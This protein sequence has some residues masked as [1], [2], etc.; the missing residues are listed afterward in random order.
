MLSYLLVLDSDRVVKDF[1]RNDHGARSG[2]LNPGPCQLA[3]RGPLLGWVSRASVDDSVER[4]NPQLPSGGGFGGDG[5]VGGGGKGAEGTR[6]QPG[7][8]L[9]RGNMGDP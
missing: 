5:H 8:D 9:E 7:G 1:F 3:R 4:L 2:H 6:S